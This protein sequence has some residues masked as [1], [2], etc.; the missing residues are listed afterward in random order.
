MSVKLYITG[1]LHQ[2]FGDSHKN[3]QGQA[4]FKRAVVA[5]GTWIFYTFANYNDAQHG[6]SS[7]NYKILVP[8]QN[9][10]ISTVNGSMYLVPDAVKG[11]L[12]FE[13]SFYGGERQVTS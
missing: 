13:H 4:T 6:G 8:G 3:L 10:D 7:Q 5:T 12:L 11:L 2:T 9:E 1:G